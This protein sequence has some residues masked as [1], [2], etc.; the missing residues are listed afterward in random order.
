[1]T[2]PGPLDEEGFH[3]LYRA[4]A[5]ALTGYV[6]SLTGSASETEDLVQETYLRLLEKA[7]EGLGAE[8]SRAWL[9]TTATR[10]ARERWRRREL[11]RRWRTERPSPETVTN[12]EPAS[13]DV[14]KAL[15]HLS[16]RQRAMLWLAYVEGRTHREIAAAVGVGAGSV[17]VL[18]FRARRR[19]ERALRKLDPQDR[20]DRE[21]SDAH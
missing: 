4:T 18:L 5:P 14:A 19:L 2:E 10:L 7:P 3:R 16:L 8:Q 6:R 12:P 9:Y 21:E 1:M 15:K 20:E 13:S 11:A 17:R